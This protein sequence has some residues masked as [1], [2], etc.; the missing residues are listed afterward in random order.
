MEIDERHHD[1]NFELKLAHDV[2]SLDDRVVSDQI[3]GE[4]LGVVDYRLH[5]RNEGDGP[6]R[7]EF[8]FPPQSFLLHLLFGEFVLV[9]NPQELLGVD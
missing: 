3:L 8:G 5:V 4:P 9:A 2:K 7:V 1:V 6:E